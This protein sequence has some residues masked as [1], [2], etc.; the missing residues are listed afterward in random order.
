MGIRKGEW[1]ECESAEPAD[2]HQSL[3][4]ARIYT[5]LKCMVHATASPPA[6]LYK[7]GLMHPEWTIWTELS[8]FEA[9]ILQQNSSWWIPTADLLGGW[10]R[11]ARRFR[12]GSLFVE[13]TINDAVQYSI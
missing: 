3:Y 13:N 11:I 1:R 5:T 10:E 6:E 8:V 7:R 4:L 2:D 9:T 12:L